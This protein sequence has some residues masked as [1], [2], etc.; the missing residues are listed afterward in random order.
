MLFFPGPFYIQSKTDLSYFFGSTDGTNYE[1]TQY[2]GDR[3]IVVSPGLT[4]DAG[5]VSFESVDQPGFYL[6]HY[7]YML[8]L[9]PKEGG[10][11]PDIFD[12]DATFFPIANKYYSGFVSFE[13]FNYRHY[14]I[15]HE[16]YRLKISEAQATTLFMMDASFR[17]RLKL[18]VYYGNYN[19]YCTIA[20]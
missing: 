16:N 17:P 6:R 20:Y 12:E 14:Y 5:T 13:S 11:N 1:I 9:E 3:F 4:G 2:T 8:C 19:D 7:N 15:R 10:R 18:P